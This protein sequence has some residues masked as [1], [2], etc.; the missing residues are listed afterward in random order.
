MYAKPVPELVS[1]V[2]N[3]AREASRYGATHTDQAGLAAAQQASMNLAVG[4]DPANLSLSVSTTQ[5][6]GLTYIYVNGTYRF[7]SV[8]PLVAALLGDPI[9]IRVVTSAPAG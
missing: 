1:V 4:V 3:A 8:T 5:M 9:S 2:S 7:H 6:D